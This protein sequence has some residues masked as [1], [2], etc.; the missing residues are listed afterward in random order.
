MRASAEARSRQTVGAGAIALSRCSFDC[1]HRGW[2]IPSMMNW[3]LVLKSRRALVVG[4]HMLL[5]V[6]CYYLAFLLRFDGELVKSNWQSLIRM[7]P[8][9]A[10][11]ELLTFVPYGLYRG[12][13]RYIGIHD[14]RNIVEAT[15]VA[16]SISYLL[17]QSV[18]QEPGYPRSVYIINALLLVVVLGG[19]RMGRRIYH[20]LG[21]LEA[22]ARRVLIIGAGDAGELIVRDMLN[23][24]FYNLQPV[25]FIDDDR[26][27][28]GRTIHNVRVLGTRRDLAR[29]I[30]SRHPDEILVA[31]NR[32]D[33]RLLREI[34]RSLD[35]YKLPIKTLPCLRDVI[36]GNVTVSQIRNVSVEDLLHRGPVGLDPEPLRRLIQGRRVLITGAGGSIGSEL[37]RQVGALNA[38]VL[39][40]FER[41][42]KALYTIEG[43]LLT[44]GS[45]CAIV[46]AIG[47]VTDAERVAAVFNEFRP[48]VVIHA[49][50]HKHVPLVQ[51]NP[52]EAVKNNIRG[53]RLVAE[54]A[55]RF[56]AERFILISTDKAVQP[57]S[58]MGATKRAAELVVRLV[59]LQNA[60]CFAMIRFGNVLG[61]NGSVIPKFLDQIKRGGP[62]TVTHP[63]VERFFMTIPE[64]VNLVL[65]SASLNENWGTLRTRHGR[66]HQDRRYGAPS[67]SPV[68]ADS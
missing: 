47:D 24:A 32:A 33:P 54:T 23:N 15:L 61:S 51:Q 37:C 2:G 31:I 28:V 3:S 55:A 65:H 45:T 10:S 44:R 49:A 1:S 58:V 53:T 34:V 60:T 13:W 62:V 66:S 46:P 17:I 52:C 22:T 57:S 19:A 30:E 4:L 18:L 7:L 63:E 48:E 40:L 68:R 35:S 39:I 64:A 26:T 9:V 43:D 12:L 14:L 41:Y 21:S 59:S 56:G 42:E 50:A 11:V 6:A 5:V 8:L 16:T 20:E 38:G 67:D 29:I 25:G 36:N 27:K